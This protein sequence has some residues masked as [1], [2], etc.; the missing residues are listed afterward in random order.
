[1]GKKENDLDKRLRSFEKKHPARK[2]RKSSLGSFVSS[3]EKQ[4]DRHSKKGR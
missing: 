4:L 2:E 1:M 3:I